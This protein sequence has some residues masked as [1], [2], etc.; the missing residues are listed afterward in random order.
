MLIF[1]AFFMYE[2][3]LFIIFVCECVELQRKWCEITPYDRQKPKFCSCE[4]K[5]D[6]WLVLVQRSRQII[7]SRTVLERSIAL[8]S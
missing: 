8:F 7:V 1:A 2:T 3:S 5:F 4:E 6:A